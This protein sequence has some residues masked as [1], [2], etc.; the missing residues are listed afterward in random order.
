MAFV[1]FTSDCSQYRL[2]EQSV[3]GA[4]SDLASPAATNNAWNGVF[5][6]VFTFL[7]RM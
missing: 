4:S 5:F 2:L 6:D 3:T 1:S 7:P